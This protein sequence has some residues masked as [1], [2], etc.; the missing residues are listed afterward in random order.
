MDSLRICLGLQLSDR[1]EA[2]IG[3]P[4]SPS[5]GLDVTR[6]DENFRRPAICRDD[7][8]ATT[9]IGVIST[10]ISGTAKPAAVSNVLAGNSLP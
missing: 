6:S 5:S 3:Q 2:G 7:Y 9:A 10:M 4:P 8:P 1:R